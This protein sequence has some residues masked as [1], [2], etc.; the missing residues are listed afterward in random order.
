MSG[1]DTI[2]PE[3]VKLSANF[4]TPLLTK[5]IST[6]IL[7]NIFLENAKT[8]S[9]IPLDKGKP[10]KNEISNLYESKVYERSIKDQIVCGMENIFHRFHQRIAKV[11]VHKTSYKSY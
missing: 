5:A 8:A 2:P 1:S 10:N 9:V 7:Q 3:L 11:T 6:S 4:L